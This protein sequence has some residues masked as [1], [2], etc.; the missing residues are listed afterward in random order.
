MLC[1]YL[2]KGDVVEGDHKKSD[3]YVHNVTATRDEL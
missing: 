3:I 1:K 2:V